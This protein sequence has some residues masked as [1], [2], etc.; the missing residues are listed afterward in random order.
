M[1]SKKT[2]LLLAIPLF[3]L[4]LLN[5]SANGQNRPLPVEKIVFHGINKVSQAE[6]RAWFGWNEKMMFSLDVLNQSCRN[7]LT[8]Y[9]EL[10]FPFAQLDSVVYRMNPIRSGIIIDVYIQASREVRIGQIVLSGIDST[11]IVPLKSRFEMKT[12]QRVRAE[13]LEQDI[14]DALSF[15]DRQGYP[16][17]R[18]DLR[19]VEIEHRSDI[20]EMSFNWNV[21]SGPKLVIKDIQ[22]AGNTFTKRNVILREIRIP[23]GSVYNS[24]KVDHISERLNKLGFFK[25]ISPPQIFWIS[26]DEGGLF[27]DVEEGNSSKFDGILGYNPGNTGK[28]GYF[29]GLIDISLGNLFGTGRIMQAHMQKRDQKSQDLKFYYREPWVAS[30]PISIGGGFEQ[31]IQDSTYVQRKMTLDVNMPLIENFS[32]HGELARVEIT[33]DSIGSY[34][35][36]ITR[37]RTLSAAIGIEY[38]SRN[39]LF[40]PRQGIYYQTGVEAGSKINLGPYAVIQQNN[41]KQSVQNKR[42]FVDIEFYWPV[43]KREVIMITLHGRQIQSNENFIALSDQFRMGGSKT[44]RGYREFQFMGSRVAW[45]NAEFRYILGRRSRVFVFM[46]NGYYYSEN[47]QSRNEAYKIGYGFGFRLETGLGIMGIDYGLGKGDSIMNGKIH[48]SLVNEF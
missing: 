11:Q 46:D 35:L 4:I 32:L 43:L 28:G 40:N 31:L 10:G 6:V 27:L 16:F 22:I 47:P 45:S 3:S 36:G 1:N 38:D 17:T 20:D 9:M 18:F 42:I 29:T 44:L 21:A 37:S 13:K 12:G 39:D 24:N 30:Y 14:D 41:L 23:L 34:V 48:V 7:L 5:F 19:S 15:M 26:K 25:K 8:K 33:P 2:K